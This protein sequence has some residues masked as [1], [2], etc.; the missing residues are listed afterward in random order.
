[1]KKGG[2]GQKC[3]QYKEDCRYIQVLIFSHSQSSVQIYWS[4]GKIM[5]FRSFFFSLKSV[6]A[7]VHSFI[8]K[9]LRKMAAIGA[10]P[11]TSCGTKP[12]NAARVFKRMTNNITHPGHFSHMTLQQADSMFKNR[13]ISIRSFL[14]SNGG[15]TQRRWHLWQFLFLPYLTSSVISYR[16]EA[17]QHGNYMSNIVV[18]LASLATR[19]QFTVD[20]QKSNWPQPAV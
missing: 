10:F 3:F 11:Y 8:R 6:G 20:R 17:W 19:N 9:L 15:H 14:W 1:M 4:I 12:T 18:W 16:T 5:I 2:D 13:H 7:S